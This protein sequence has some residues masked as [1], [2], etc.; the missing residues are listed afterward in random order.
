MSTILRKDNSW[1]THIISM[2]NKCQIVLHI[3]DLLIQYGEIEMNSV[4]AEFN[5]SVRSFRRYIS[6][7]N[8]FL[9]NNFKNQY[10]KYKKSTNKYYLLNEYVKVD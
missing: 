1:P 5:I 3:Y 7:I 9:N 8:I 4:L 6:E 2:I 10:I